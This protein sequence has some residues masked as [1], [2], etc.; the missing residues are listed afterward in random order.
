MKLKSRQGVQKGAVNL[1]GEETN[2][3]IDMHVKLNT[4]KCTLTKLF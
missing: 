4:G 1:I 2:T 3:R